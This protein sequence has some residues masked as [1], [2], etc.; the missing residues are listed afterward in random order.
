[1]E[2][3][4]YMLNIRY[5]KY[6]KWIHIVS[7]ASMLGGI[8]SMLLLL[9]LERNINDP[10][11]FYP[12]DFAIYRIFNIVV[13]Y[14]FY[15]LLITAFI[16]ATYTKWGYIKHHWLI[17]KWIGVILLYAL[18]WFGWDQA[19]NGI[20]ALSDGG[21][22]IAGSPEVYQQQHR[23]SYSLT[24]IALLIL[25]FTFLISTL[26]P[27][28]IRKKLIS[29]R[30]KWIIIISM[31]CFVLALSFSL[32][33][34]LSLSYYRNIPIEDTKLSGLADGNYEGEANIAGYSYKVL[35]KLS[36]NKISDIKIIQNRKSPY[37]RFAE[38]IIPRI[39]EKQN[40]NVQAIS[41]ATTTSKALMKAVEKAF[42]NHTKK[43]QD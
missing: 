13:I 1:M 12:I 11:S 5:L 17:V 39:I 32:L 42:L 30:R 40:A 7:A 37:A 31:I 9:S 3:T 26:K 35:V 18:V 4:G 19:I 25:V 24:L 38:G 2:E 28:G 8:L 21:F 27:W 16:Y 15:F 43:N 14:S 6:V 33:S 22:Q 20:A 41:G 29:I 23:L 34:Y 10:G 36:G